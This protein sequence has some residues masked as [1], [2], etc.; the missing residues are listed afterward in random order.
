ME[1]FD[2]RRQ[3]DKKKLMMKKY[4]L[5][6]SLSGGSIHDKAFNGVYDFGGSCGIG[7]TNRSS[8]TLD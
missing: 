3:E 5:P 7:L 1:Y 8:V 4:F 2:G 6:F